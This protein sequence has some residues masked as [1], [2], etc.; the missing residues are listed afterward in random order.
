MK[1]SNVLPVLAVSGILALIYSL[2]KKGQGLNEI[3]ARIT[4]VN[5]SGLDLYV[6][7]QIFNPSNESLMIDSIS[8]NV[9]F[10]NVQI[11][12]IQ[13]INKT[14]IQPLGYSEFK[15]IKITL[16]PTGIVTLTT[17]IITR[18]ETSGTLLIDGK[19]FVGGIAL[20]LQQT[21]KAW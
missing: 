7:L 5:I 20:P 17:R 4:G 2:V 10:N 3:T 18:Q 13:F 8:A 14:P 19:L 6:N 16:S 9:Y 1:K 11:G 21:F 12:T 15:N